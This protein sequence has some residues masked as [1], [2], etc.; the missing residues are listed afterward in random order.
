[1]APLYCPTQ[2]RSDWIA[3]RSLWPIAL[4]VS[5]GDCNAGRAGTVATC[6]GLAPAVDGVVV[7]AWT[8]A[9][10]ATN[11]NVAIS[12][13]LMT[14]LKSIDE[15][16]IKHICWGKTNAGAVESIV[17]RARFNFLPLVFLKTSYLIP[18]ISFCVKSAGPAR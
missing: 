14:V 12:I 6:F 10:V 5:A 17:S 7:W 9:M 8:A 15:A 3:I 4:A 18:S 13:D 16:P 1:M 11:V 2:A